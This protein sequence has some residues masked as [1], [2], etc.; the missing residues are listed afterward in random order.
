MEH[1]EAEA[2]MGDSRRRTR[3]HRAARRGAA[4]LAVLVGLGALLLGATPAWAHNALVEASPKKDAKLTA[5][6]SAVK[7][8]FLATLKSDGTK[9]TVAGPDAAAAAGPVTVTG[10]TVSVPFTGAASGVYTVAYEVLSKD[11]HLVK[12]SYK[13]SLAVAESAAPSPSPRTESAQASPSASPAAASTAPVAGTDTGGP[14]WPW[15]GGAT[16]AGLLVGGVINLV[17]KRREQ[18]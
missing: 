5:A 13:F 12:G 3:E 7:L 18:A 15:V 16:V 6:P 14:W 1:N 9:L 8:T 4:V 11:G 10:K 2:I 17:R